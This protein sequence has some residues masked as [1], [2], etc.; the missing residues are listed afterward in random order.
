MEDEF[1]DLG[2]EVPL[3][4]NKDK[5]S[6]PLTV[7]PPTGSKKGPE[8]PHRRGRGAGTSEAQS[9]P[10][11]SMSDYP[12]SMPSL[13]AVPTSPGG[14]G[15]GTSTGSRAMSDTPDIWDCGEAFMIDFAEVDVLNKVGEGNTAEVFKGKWRGNHV[16]IKKLFK[17]R[18]G[19][20]HTELIAISREVQVLSKLSHPNLVHFYGFSTSYPLKVVTE[21][22]E[23][24]SLFDLLHNCDHIDIAWKQRHKVCLDVAQ[25][26]HSLHSGSPKVI[27]RDLKSHNLLLAKPV[28]HTND[29]VHVKVADFGLARM[30]D[31]DGDWGRMTNQA[32]S[33][34]WMAPEVIIGNKYDEKVDVY[35][36]GIVLFELLSRSIP[37][38][39]QTGA[40]VVRIIKAGKRPDVDEVPPDCPEGLIHL[41]VR[42]WVQE[43]SE[44]P[45]FSQVIDSLERGH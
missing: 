35:S 24:G 36:Y 33:C 27:H 2:E 30:A 15:Y 20:D 6:G 14:H 9:R 11:S 40:E 10:V 26:M 4:V 3:S 8:A 7:R 44:R 38:N 25:A 39:E 12:E 17:S 32:G 42:C 18:R 5:V 21:F 41:M 29:P 28:H 22:C 31:L 16:A 34:H 1:G 43:P 19:L 23:G 45:S 37:F 13:T